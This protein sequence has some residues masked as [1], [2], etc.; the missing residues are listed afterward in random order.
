METTPRNFADVLHSMLCNIPADQTELISDLNSD[1]TAG[2]TTA[3]EESVQWTRASETLFKH[4]GEPSEDWQFIVYS[5]FSGL[6][7]KEFW[8]QNCNS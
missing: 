1:I 2:R 5:I 3:P 4:I 6:T 7:V 8:E